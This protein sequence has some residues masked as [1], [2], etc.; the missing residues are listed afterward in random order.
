MLSALAPAAGAAPPTE[1]I[2]SPTLWIATIAGVAALF[3]VD[4]LI[5]C[6]LYTS[7]SPRD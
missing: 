5:T 1:S 4:F 7:P 2:G 6:L 3:L